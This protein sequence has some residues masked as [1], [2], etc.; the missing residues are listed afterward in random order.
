MTDALLLD[1]C[2]LLWLASG[3]AALSEKAREKMANAAVLYVSPITAWEIAVKTAKGKILLPCSAREWFHA[4][5]KRY[6]IQVLKMAADEM[7][8]S[9]ALPWHHKDPADRF[10]IATA[11]QSGL[12]V[13]TADPNFPKYGVQTIC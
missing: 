2:A 7:L 5:V 3:D 13:V 6:G 8:A 10:I 1:T 11:L 9:A 4:V 12:V